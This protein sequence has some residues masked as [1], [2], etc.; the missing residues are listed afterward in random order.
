MSVPDIWK[1]R[2]PWLLLLMISATFTGMIITGFE[3]ALQAQVV[4][5]AFIPMLMD[6]GGNSGSQSSVSVI[7][8][9][10]LREVEFTDYFTVLW[11]EIRVSAICGGTLAV[12]NFAKILLVDR[13]LLG[14]NEVTVS[15]AAVICITLF[16]TVVCAKIV[17]CSLPMLAAKLKFDPAV[18]A[19]PFITTIVD[20]ISLLIY[21]QI[22]KMLL[23]F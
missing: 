9:L 14:N 7:R 21:F 3:N 10:A 20:A 6:T 19:S 5:T 1:V 12:V 13:M 15:V 11:K 17:G 4:L 8:S 16:L 23:S 18:M 2:M 22:A